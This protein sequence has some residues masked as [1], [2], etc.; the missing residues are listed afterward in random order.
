[1]TTMLRLERQGPLAVVTLDRPPAN[2]LNRD[3]FVELG[4]LLRTLA[5]PDVHAVV[6]TG[7]GGRVFSAGLDL[8]EILTYQGADAIDFMARFDDGF[9]GLF[10]LEKPVVAAV[11]GHAIAGGAVLAA[12]AA[13][14][15]R[16]SRSASRSPPP[17]S[18]SFASRARGPRSPSCS[19]TAGPTRPRRHAVAGWSTRSCP[20][21]SSCRAPS[22]SRA[23]SPR[24]R[25]R[26]SR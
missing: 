24:S 21:P 14:A 25:P 9:A 5:A 17:H 1:M 7:S 10:A 3:F 6:I 23:S 22:R 26:R 19:T 12:T 16:R 20:P 18:R 11:N 4:A 15:S 2:A 8:F 13:S